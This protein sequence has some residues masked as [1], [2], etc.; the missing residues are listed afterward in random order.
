MSIDF[1]P[2]SLK[3][4]IESQWAEKRLRNRVG[5]VVLYGPNGEIL[6]TAE[7]SILNMYECAKSHVG[8]DPR[9]KAL[10]S[11]NSCNT[12]EMAKPTQ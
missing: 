12:I 5:D 3:H 10:V 4:V 8:R 9:H 2:R 6:C 11:E 1:H 7:G